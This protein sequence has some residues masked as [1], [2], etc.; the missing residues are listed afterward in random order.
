MNSA[1][2]REQTKE[3]ERKLRQNIWNVY[4]RDLMVREL[5]EKRISLKQSETPSRLELLACVCIVI[6]F[7]ITYCIGFAEFWYL[8]S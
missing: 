7:S 5:K 6:I 1:D 2:L 4:E 8:F 3:L